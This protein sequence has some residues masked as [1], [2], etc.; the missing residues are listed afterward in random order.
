[1]SSRKIFTASLSGLVLCLAVASPPAQAQSSF[2]GGMSGKPAQNPPPAAEPEPAPAP[3]PDPTP[4]APAPAPFKPSAPAAATGF[5][6]SWTGTYT[7]A[8]GL[9]GIDIMFD[10]P[11]NGEITAVFSFYA[12]A[13]NPGVPSGRFRVVGTAP[14]PGDRQ[15]TLFPDAWIQR[16]TGYAMVGVDLQL[17]PDGKA[18]RGKL[19][20]APGCT[21]ALLGRNG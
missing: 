16:P 17:T 11:A 3:A 18:M 15:L 21:T 7:C 20:G 6:G 8:Q 13:S 12:V 10:A 2:L 14:G 4:A 1:M 19:S 9:T 5:S